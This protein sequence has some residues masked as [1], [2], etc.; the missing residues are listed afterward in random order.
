MKINMKELQPYKLLLPDKLIRLGNPDGDG[1][2][3]I[4]KSL[5]DTCDILYS[6][7][8]GTDS[9]F[10]NDWTK[11]TTSKP[12]HLYDY[13][14]NFTP[15]YPQHT[16]HKEGLSGFKTNN[17]NNFLN[18]LTEN[19]DCDRKVLLKVDVEGAEYEWLRHTNISELAN[20]VNGL[21]IEFH[22]VYDINLNGTLP[23]LQEYFNIIHLH[24]NNFGG[25]Y[26]GIPVVPEITFLNKNIPIGELFVGQ[27]PLQGLDVRNNVNNPNEWNYTF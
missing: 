10:E 2:Y 9:S 19:G 11:L 23:R 27:L 7:G 21:I 5:L 8:V 24:S 1:G 14:I 26:N 17:C 12:A 25:I 15:I 22:D 3:L 16:F 13:T 18:H 4:A 20:S 6:Y